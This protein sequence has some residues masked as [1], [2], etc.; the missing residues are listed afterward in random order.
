MPARHTLSQRIVACQHLADIG[1][2]RPVL[3]QEYLLRRYSLP[4][5]NVSGQAMN[6]EAGQAVQ[7]DNIQARIQVQTQQVKSL[8]Q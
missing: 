8:S 1:C 4:I 7:V 6:K 2:A 5:I 3:W